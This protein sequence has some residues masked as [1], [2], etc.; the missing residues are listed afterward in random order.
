MLPNHSG[1][2]VELNIFVDASHADDK[3]DRK[4]L[5]G[6]LIYVG[7]MLIKSVSKRQK[8]VATSTFSSWYLVLK[9]AVEEV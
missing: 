5:T 9:T 2:K 6:I 1:D 3:I 8:S 7:D 4:S